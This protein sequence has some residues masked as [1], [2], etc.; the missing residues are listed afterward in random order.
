[1]TH[2]E[3]ILDAVTYI[4]ECLNRGNQLSHHLLQEIDFKSGYIS[5]YLPSST[6]IEQA[7]QF[8][9][10]GKLK[11]G[12]SFISNGYKVESVPTFDTQ[13]IETIQHHLQQNRENLCLFED[14]L[15]KP[16]D[17]FLK[18]LN[19]PILVYQE[20]IYF[21]LQDLEITSEKIAQVINNTTGARDF[22]CAFSSSHVDF[23]NK[24]M[25]TSDQIQKLA[26]NTKKVAVGAYDGE[27]YL[28][29]QNGKK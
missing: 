11:S 3:I 4:Q 6:S 29:W 8:Y 26:Q 9:T 23:G 21:L 28:I 19:H 14:I 20:Q 22:L 12:D 25:I 2:K 7:Q 27:G 5:S 1:M 15:S 16:S 13:L 24:R 10:G 18:R 17:P